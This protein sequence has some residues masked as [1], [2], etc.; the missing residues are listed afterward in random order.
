MGGTVSFDL[1]L[2]DGSSVELKGCF[3]S[4][5]VDAGASCAPGSGP[6]PYTKVCSDCQCTPRTKIGSGSLEACHGLCAAINSCEEFNFFA[7]S[8][9]CYSCDS[10]WTQSSSKS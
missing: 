5:P 2:G 9:S 6:T 10:G 3:D 8:T 7:S 4:W 1:T